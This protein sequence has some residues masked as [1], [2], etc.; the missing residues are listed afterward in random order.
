MKSIP[1]CLALAAAAALAAPA[2]AEPALMSGDWTRGLCQAW[3]AEPVLTGKLAESGWVKNDKGRG[4]KVI[5]LY[6]TECGSRPTGELRLSL[7][8]GKAACVYGGAAQT[9]KLDLS[10]DYLMDAETPRWEEM[11]RGEYGPMKAMMFGRLS[12]DGP[13]GE[14]MGNMGPFEAFLA[15]VGKVPYDAK[16]C[17]K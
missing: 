4:F 16:T 7:K 2:F 12:F 17:A 15:L 11:G 6:R 14:A 1:K 10:A 8:D 13:M 9:A 5:Q 3:N